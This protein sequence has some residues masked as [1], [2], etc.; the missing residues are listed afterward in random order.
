MPTTLAA[1]IGRD[2]GSSASRRLRSTGAVPGVVYGMG[3]E[4]V[5]VAVA[6]SELRAILASEGTNALINLE[7]NG[8]K[9]LTLVKE[10]QRHPVRRDVIH[11]D[12]LIVDPNKP[13][14]VEVPIQLEGESEHVKAEGGVIEQILFTLPVMARPDAIP[15]SLAVSVEEMT[16]ADPVR[17]EEIEL[18]E[19]V[20]TEVEESAVVATAQ[21]SR[22]A[23]AVEEADA[24]LAAELLEGEEIEGEEVEGEEGEEVE[25]AEAEGEDTAEASSEDADE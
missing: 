18:P 17:V 21:I 14:H 4:P 6:W 12:F 9:Q 25:G 15:Q 5:S 23:L 7:Y 22:A 13:I 1:E 11:V 2:L 10:L 8:A 19:G 20:T 3:S 24:E 16:L